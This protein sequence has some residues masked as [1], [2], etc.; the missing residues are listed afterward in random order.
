MSCVSARKTWR[1]YREGQ[2]HFFAELLAYKLQ[3]IL[4][5]LSSCF[6]WL[7]SADFAAFSAYVHPLQLALVQYLT[8]LSAH[9]LS[10]SCHENKQ[11][12][13]HPMPSCSQALAVCLIDLL[14]SNT[15]FPFESGNAGVVDQSAYC[16]FGLREVAMADLHAQTSCITCH[17]LESGVTAERR[18]F[19]QHAMPQCSLWLAH[20]G[21]HNLLE[22][23]ECTDPMPYVALLGEQLTLWTVVHY[24]QP[25]STKCVR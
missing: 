9:M 18:Y 15:L 21:Q 7:A 1:P 8:S 13:L 12:F 2:Q 23:E 14:V 25:V 19:W 6:C 24:H 11:H 5:F 4:T 16:A 22:E 10:I 17:L 20:V 3:H